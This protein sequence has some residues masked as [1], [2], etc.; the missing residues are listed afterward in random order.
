VC[1]EAFARAEQEAADFRRALCNALGVDP[2]VIVAPAEIVDRVRKVCIEAFARAEQEAEDFR[3]AL[4]NALGIEDAHKPAEVVDRVRNLRMAHR[5]SVSDV[6]HFSG[7]VSENTKAVDALAAQ[8]TRDADFRTALCKVLDRPVESSLEDIVER[9]GSLVTLL[10]NHEE[11][12]RVNQ[13]FRGDLVKVLGVPALRMREQ[14]LDAVADLKR[15]KN[16]LCEAITIELGGGPTQDAAGVLLAVRDLKAEN[17]KLCAELR[18]AADRLAA[19]RGDDVDRLFEA[20]HRTVARL[21][22]I[23]PPRGPNPGAA[24]PLQPDPGRDGCYWPKIG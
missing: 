19:R 15:A 24:G 18:Q 2:N 9:V 21:K 13:Q 16:E 11:A 3:R 1:I 5:C 12:Q 22:E 7:L 17:E 20:I 4:C 8:I 10:R 14:I 6:A 23:D